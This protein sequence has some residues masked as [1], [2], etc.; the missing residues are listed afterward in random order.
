M[1]PTPALRI[2]NFMRPCT[3]PQVLITTVASFRHGNTLG[4]RDAAGQHRPQV[5]PEHAKMQDL[6][7][8]QL[9]R[10]H[11]R[12]ITTRKEAVTTCR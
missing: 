9:F 8:R 5:S 4:N 12:W 3:L 10:T 11:E 7:H 6:R 2:D 1:E